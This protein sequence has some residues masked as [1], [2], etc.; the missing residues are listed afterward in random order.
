VR[1]RDDDDGSYSSFLVEVDAEVGRR[2]EAAQGDATLRLAPGQT[3][4]RRP[5]VGS[6]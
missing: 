6:A 5:A 3:E 2:G 1:V 4:A